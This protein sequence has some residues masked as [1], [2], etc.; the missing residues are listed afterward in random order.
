MVFLIVK[1]I[2]ANRR[3]G[4]NRLT[5]YYLTEEEAE[6]IRQDKRVYCVE[7]PADQRDDIL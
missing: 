5:H 7:I 2:V 6:L 4:S 3:V 1:L